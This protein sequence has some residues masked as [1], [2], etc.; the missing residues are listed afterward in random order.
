M[1]IKEEIK[2][3]GIFWLPPF[4]LKNQR[5]EKKTGHITPILEKTLSHNLLAELPYAHT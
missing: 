1:K 4:N 2:K 3:S 5:I